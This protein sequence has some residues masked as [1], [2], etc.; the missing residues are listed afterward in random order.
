MGT[1]FRMGHAQNKR[2]LQYSYHERRCFERGVVRIAGETCS[3]FSMELASNDIGK[4]CPRPP[5]LPLLT[6]QGKIVVDF[7]VNLRALRKDGGGFFFDCPRAL[8]PA[9]VEKTPGLQLR[10]EVAVEDLSRALRHGAVWDSGGESDYG[11]CFADPRLAAL[12]LRIILPPAVAA[13]AA[14]GSG[15]TLV[16]A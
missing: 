11:L 2:T 6:P 3:A 16:G 10:A 1:S 9:L 12:G 13:E 8:A 7:I 15:A 4:G 5:M 14:K